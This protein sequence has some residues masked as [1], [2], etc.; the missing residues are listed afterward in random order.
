ML[1]ILKYDYNS[2]RQ[3]KKWRKNKDGRKSKKRKFSDSKRRFLCKITLCCRLCSCKRAL[4]LKVGKKKFTVLF[5]QTS[6]MVECYCGSFWVLN[7]DQNMNQDQNSFFGSLK[8]LT[9][10]LGSNQFKELTRNC[11]L[12]SFISIFNCKDAS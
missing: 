12:K 10:R 7:V 5:R 9:L 6:I 1:L 4:N 2:G 3:N 11:I 8:K